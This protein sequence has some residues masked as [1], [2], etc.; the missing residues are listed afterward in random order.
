V[1][2]ALFIMQLLSY[3]AV[4]HIDMPAVVA[5]CCGR[6]PQKLPFSIHHLAPSGAAV[7][8]IWKMAH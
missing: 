1:L 5:A 6:L 8:M 4:A 3:P 2:P 7:G